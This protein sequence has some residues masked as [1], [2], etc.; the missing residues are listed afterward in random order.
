M[1]PGKC[2]ILQIGTYWMKF[3]RR[4]GRREWT[5]AEWTNAHTGEWMN[6]KKNV[7]QRLSGR[8]KNWRNERISGLVRRILCRTLS[9]INNIIMHQSIPAA[10]SLP[11]PR[12][13]PRALAFV[14]PL[15]WQI[16]G[17]GDS[18]AVKSP[19]VGTKK[20][21]KCPVLHQHCN[22]F[23]WLHSRTVTF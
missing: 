23:H 9:D 21:G 2:K 20:E 5:N 10:S 11:P 4:K 6:E 22:I 15:G 14:L 16:P 1:S 17:D 7:I 3:K 8:V 19:G 12:A 13:H 18:W